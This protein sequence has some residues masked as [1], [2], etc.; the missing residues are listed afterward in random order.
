M[1]SIITV[2]VSPCI[3][4]CTTVPVLVPDK[5]LHCGIV[6]K[7]PGGG[8]INVSRVLK[9]LG[10]ETTAIYLAGGY[11]G[12]F[13][14][15]MMKDEN[16]DTLVIETENHTRENFVVAETSK[17][18]QYRFGMPGP[19]IKE[20]EW[21]QCLDGISSFKD[22][23]YIVASGSLTAGVPTDFF[24]RLA[25]IAKNKQAKMILDTSGEAM[26]QAL[27]ETVYLI[28]PNLGELAFLSGEKILTKESAIQA[29]KKMIGNGQCEIV[30]VSMGEDGA[31]MVTNDMI[32]HLVAPVV[33]RKSTVGAG[34]SMVAGIVFSLSKN[35]SLKEALQYGVA[36][37]TA[38]TMNAGT[39]LCNVDDVNT[40]FTFLQGKN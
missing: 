15:R 24:A 28:K 22:V 13:F 21:Q 5:K 37:G 35:K 32:E 19:F 31:I 12:S 23:S 3:D 34:D 10:A 6:K 16:V 4:I 38:T 8:G 29:A 40:L 17:N 25:A 20:K 36:C 14:N 11:T 30:V 18:L 1:S 33:E 26:Y 39:A 9:R 27:K 2:T 7:E